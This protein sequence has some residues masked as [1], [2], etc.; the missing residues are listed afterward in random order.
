M[1]KHTFFQGICFFFKSLPIIPV[2]IIL[3]VFSSIVTISYQHQLKE[4]GHWE[5]RLNTEIE[6]YEELLKDPNIYDRSRAQFENKLEYMIESLETGVNPY[7]KTF[8]ESYQDFGQVIIFLQLIIIYIVSKDWY[9]TWNKNMKTWFL[10]TENR[11]SNIFTMKIFSYFIF[12]SLISLISFMIVS[13]MALLSPLYES[14]LPASYEEIFAH[15]L[16]SLYINL[17]LTAFSVLVMTCFTSNGGIILSLAMCIGL[18]I[19]SNS[20]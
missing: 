2:A 10:N 16:L 20:V 9:S 17:F 18:F 3:I 11:L 13:L 5:Q 1:K 6:M 8:L 15:F 12:V 14:V 7:Q 19:I 4:Y